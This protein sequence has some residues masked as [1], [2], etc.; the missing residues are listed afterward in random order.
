L[1]IEA[2]GRLRHLTYDNAG[3]L[4]TKQYPA[5]TA[6]NI[7]Y[8][9]DATAGGNKGVGR[10]T[11]IDDASGSV[12]WTYDALGR[13]TQEKKTTA[14]IV[15]TVG[16]AYDADRNLTQV[17]YPSGRTVS[18]A[19]D[20]LG[21]ISGVTTQKDASSPVVTLASSVAYQPFGPLQSLWYGNGLD[22]WKT[23]T[24]DYLL[25]VLLVEDTSVPQTLVSRAHTRTDNLNLTNIW[26]NVDACG[27]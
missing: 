13:V 19:R 4:L 22:L 8:T 17:T 20:S 26:D 24:S 21:R 5:A 9:W 25:D 12:E 11:R 6:E 1:P 10:L 27:N 16:Y 7:A 18:Y 23:F 3:R 15:Y 14:T 2:D